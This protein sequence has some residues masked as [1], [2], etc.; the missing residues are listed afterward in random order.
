MPVKTRRRRFDRAAEAWAAISLSLL[1][2]GIVVLVLFAPNYLAIG[3]AIITL[4]FVVTESVL[5]AAFIQTIGQITAL[6]AIISAIILV[7]HFWSWLLM[8]ALVAVAVFLLWQRL[9][10]LTG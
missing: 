1:L 2:L 5:R 6:L 9:R 8:G 4:L 7:I 3:L 10:E